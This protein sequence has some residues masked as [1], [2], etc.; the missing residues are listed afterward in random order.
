[1]RWRN[2]A[3]VLLALSACAAPSPEPGKLLGDALITQTSAAARLAYERGEFSL[4]QPLYRRAL[5][6]ARAINDAALAADAA[7]NLAVSEIALGNYAVAEQL[8]SDAGYDAQRA[9]SATDDIL[10]LRA[11]V[12]YLLKRLPQA[13]TLA[14]AVADATVALSLRLQA[15]LLRGQI[16]CERGEVASARSELQRINGLGAKGDAELAPAIRADRAK[17]EGTIA[18]LEGNMAT[19]A[20]LFDTEAEW[21]RGAHRYRDMGYALARAADSY[22]AAAQPNLAADRYYLAARSLDARGERADTQTF[23]AASIGAAEKAG[24]QNSRER[25]QS[26]LDE[27]SRRGGP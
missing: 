14:S 19:A 2:L 25:A 4:A 18:R 10:L 11:K 16:Y 27:I 6:R 13:L 15:M 1:M 24:N 7:Y 5:T 21:L 26:L 23:L 8:L 12:A 17:L 20:R 22:L 9:A 3:V